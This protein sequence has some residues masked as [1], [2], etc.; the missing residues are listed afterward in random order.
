MITFHTS[1]ESFKSLANQFILECHSHS[2][3][4]LSS[5]SIKWY[6]NGILIDTLSN[7]KYSTANQSGLLQLLIS[8]PNE[9]D[10][11]EYRC[12]IELSGHPMQ[13]I[14]H[15]VTIEPSIATPV[16][17]ERQKGRYHQH[18]NEK[19]GKER[20]YAIQKTIKREHAAPIALAS[21]LKNLTI[22][23]GSRAKFVCSLVGNAEFSVEWF[24]NNIP[25]EAD[26]RYR[27]T[28]SDAIVG[29]EISDVIPSDSGFYTCTIKGQRNSVTSSSKL[30]VYETYSPKSHKKSLTHDRPP[31]PLS[32]S[33]FI[34][35]GKI[36]SHTHTP[37]P[38]KKKNFYRI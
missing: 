29:L 18:Q 34:R 15:T 5:S 38:L 24:K 4:H 19:E 13:S 22:E 2:S 27:T 37:Q 10:S 11:G 3:K 21:F 6:K 20:Q 35:K 28:T 16:P 26:L 36:L 31:M 8:N 9:T 25:L 32:L 23:E 12:E 33:E 30:T 1:S 17:E 7:R 14:S